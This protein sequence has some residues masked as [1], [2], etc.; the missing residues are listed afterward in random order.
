MS[1]EGA[2]FTMGV[3]GGFILGIVLSLQY[4][5]VSPAEIKQC[6]AVCQD[7]GGIHQIYTD[8][9]CQCKNKAFFY[10]EMQPVRPGIVE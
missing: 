8:S 6:K 5:S 3:V 10:Q 1:D 9:D 7:N 4:C 2:A